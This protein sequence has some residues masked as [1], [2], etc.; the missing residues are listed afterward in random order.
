MTDA[1]FTDIFTLLGD[2]PEDMGIDREDW[3]TEC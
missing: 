2:T 1:E 3:I